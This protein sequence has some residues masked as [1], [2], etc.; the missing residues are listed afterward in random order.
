MQ[1]EELKLIEELKE[2]YTVLTT[3]HGFKTS[4][5]EYESNYGLTDT[6]LKEGFVPKFL[7]I[8]LVF[9]AS[10]FHF[11]WY[12]FMHSLLLPQPSSMLQME[13]S[14]YIDDDMRKRMKVEMR[15]TMSLIRKV[16]LVSATRDE[17]LAVKTVDE[18]MKLWTESTKELVHSLSTLMSDKWSEDEK[19]ENPSPYSYG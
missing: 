17:S 4:F 1:N 14:S 7:G 11:S 12:N 6:I 5:E 16:N 3:K 19:E 10:E 8:F 13:E 2:Q 15:K 18:F 9:R